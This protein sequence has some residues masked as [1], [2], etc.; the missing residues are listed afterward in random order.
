MRVKKMPLSQCPSGGFENYWEY[1][2]GE[3]F[4]AK[5]SMCSKIYFPRPQSTYFVIAPAVCIY[6]FSKWSEVKPTR[7][8][9][10]PTI[11]QF[12]Y[13]LVCKY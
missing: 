2:L 6:Y 1:Y 7:D 5:L 9:S 12:L 4:E 13:E 10:A 8:K 11:P 3:I